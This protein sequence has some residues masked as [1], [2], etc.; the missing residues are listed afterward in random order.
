LDAIK[1]I[2]EDREFGDAGNR[3][4]IEERLEGHE[5]SLLCIT[6][7]R[8]IVTLPPAQDHKPAFDGDT[9]PNTGGMGAYCP[10]PLFTDE[11]LQNVTERILVPSV[12]AMKRGRNPFRGVLYAGLMITRGGPRVIEFNARFGDPETEV[13]LPRLT[14]DLFEVLLTAATG[15]LSDL[16]APVFDPRPCVGVVM[17]SGGYPGTYQAGKPIEGLEAAAALEDVAVYHAGTRRRQDGG[18]STAGGR[19]L[20]VTAKGSGFA[21]ARDRAYRAVGVIRWEDEYHRTDI[22][23]RALGRTS[24]A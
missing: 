20:C 9:G 23:H 14:S 21:D 12:H 4:I 10:T 2:A 8:T 13:M 24:P 11:M 1:R 3:I 18:L 6:D 16:E 7:G 15:K 22:A 5:V 17:A 19:V